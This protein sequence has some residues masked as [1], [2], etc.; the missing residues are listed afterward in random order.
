VT[1][2]FAESTVASVPI[3]IAADRDRAQPQ[4][5]AFWFHG[6]GVDSSTHTPELRALA[7]AG[8]LAVGVDAVGHGRRR[9]PDLDARI[10]GTQAQALVTAIHCADETARELPHIIGTLVDEGRA[11]PSRIAG[12]GIS[13][14]GYLLY[15]ALVLTPAIGTAVA[16]LGSPE[17]PH[18]DSPHLHL[19]AFRRP[20]LLSIVGERDINVPP[21]AARRLHVCLD[22]A[23]PASERHRCVVLPGAEH[24]MSAGDWHAT[25]T[26]TLSW[27][28]RHDL[29]RDDVA[30]RPSPVV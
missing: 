16:L 15:R 6:L 9:F 10:A 24:L 7:E 18:P 21:A 19:D 25:V 3:L 2:E 11:D 8:F 20:A 4:P 1:I 30:S 5:L 27:L 13:M 28:R 12:V 17:W 26:L 23:D 22:E 14:G 29:S